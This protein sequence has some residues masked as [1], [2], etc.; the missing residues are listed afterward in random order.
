MLG[1]VFFVNKYGI[2]KCSVVM[3]VGVI[4]E[5]LM[6]KILVIFLFLNCL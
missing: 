2:L 1:F 5:V 6:V 3:I 4:L